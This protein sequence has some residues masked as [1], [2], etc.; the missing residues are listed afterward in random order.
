MPRHRGNVLKEIKRVG[1]FRPHKPT[2]KDAGCTHPCMIYCSGLVS[3]QL[4]SSRWGVGGRVGILSCFC[5]RYDWHSPNRKSSS[6]EV[7]CC[8]SAR[9][10]APGRFLSH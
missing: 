5:I 7:V 4:Y 10:A 8:I 2:E 3:L 9:A 6:E 1:Y